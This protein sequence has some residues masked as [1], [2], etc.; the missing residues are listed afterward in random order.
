MP[1]ARAAGR[2][3]RATSV[4]KCQE[5]RSVQ[6]QS[7]CSRGD[8]VRELISTASELAG[9]AMAADA[10]LMSAGL[11]SI[12]ATEFATSI[13]ERLSTELSQTLLFDHPSLRSVAA[14][15]ADDCEAATAAPGP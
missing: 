7:A 2:S 1:A 6:T 3:C 8:L 10:P 14:S 9:T 4:A 15:L 5:P 13:G 12:G 11:D